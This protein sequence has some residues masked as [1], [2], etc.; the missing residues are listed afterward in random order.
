MFADP[1]QAMCKE[2]SGNRLQTCMSDAI[3]AHGALQLPYD[4]P[5][6]S[7]KLSTA[8][9]ILRR[10]CVTSAGSILSTCAECT[11]ATVAASD[12]QD[13]LRTPQE[14]SAG[15]S[16]SCLESF[17]AFPTTRLVAL[18]IPEK[19]NARRGKRNGDPFLQHSFNQPC[20]F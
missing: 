20:A 13:H 18:W 19:G 9:V 15:I 7:R 14:T 2:V 1:V 5:W 11:S 6:I 4:E 16:R 12:F 17:G 8:A 10:S 3:L